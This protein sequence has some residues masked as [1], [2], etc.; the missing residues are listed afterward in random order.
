L[1]QT[2]LKENETIQIEAIE[3]QQEDNV[4]D[5]VKLLKPHKGY[6]GSVQYYPLFAIDTSAY[7]I[8]VTKTNVKYFEVPYYERRM[9]DPLPLPPD[10]YF[11]PLTSPISLFLFLS[12]LYF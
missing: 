7:P 5:T 12:L 1:S 6:W 10:Q 3:S 11:L 8:D 4:E 2:T 9:R